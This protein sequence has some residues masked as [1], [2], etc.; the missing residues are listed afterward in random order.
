MKS[1]TTDEIYE[2]LKSC[3]PE[4]NDYF[5]STYDEEK[6][7][8]EHFG[9]DST[10]KLIVLLERR[11]VQVLEIDRSPLDEFHEKWYSEEFGKQ[12]VEERV[13]GEFWFSY[14][15]LLRIAMELEFGE[16]YERFAAIR[17]GVARKSEP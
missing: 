16:E 1:L 15:G 10:A 4:K 12:F 13:K 14:S 11:K 17:D 9:I 3:F 2:A 8:L 7:E 6:S 5:E